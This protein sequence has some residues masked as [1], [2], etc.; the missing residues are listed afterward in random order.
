[1][2]VLSHR[3]PPIKWDI[4][5]Y[6]I[7]THQLLLK[8]ST[9]LCF[10]LLIDWFKRKCW[11]SAQWIL[12]VN[13]SKSMSK[14]TIKFTFTC[15]FL[16]NFQKITSNVRSIFNISHLESFTQERISGTFTTLVLKW[17]CQTFQE[18]ILHHLFSECELIKQKKMTQRR[19]EWKQSEMSDK[20]SV[21]VPL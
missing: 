3:D 14:F 20:F 19:I 17:N 10:G 2:K 1:M 9:Y 4:W 16:S 18:N 11:I 21:L 7:I 15:T 5:S 6:R 8:T 12:K 13:T